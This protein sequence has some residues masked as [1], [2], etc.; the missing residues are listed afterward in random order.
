MIDFARVN[1]TLFVGTCPSNEV[2]IKQI[3]LMGVTGVLNLQ[4]DEDFLKWQ[5]EFPEIEQ[6]SYDL[7]LVI[8]RVP[9]IDFDDED[10]RTH[11]PSAVNLLHRMIAVGHTIYLHCTA[12]RDRSPTV[13]VAYLA[14]HKDMP[15]EEAVA[16][17]K[18]LRE[19]QPKIELIE[20]FLQ[21]A[22]SE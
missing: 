6:A 20:E 19:C 9:I 14:K 4:T 13:A 12:G 10:L 15:V 11:L 16:Y 5:V 3:R 1:S 21:N 8:Q 7:D 2:D 22:T 18:S 17:L